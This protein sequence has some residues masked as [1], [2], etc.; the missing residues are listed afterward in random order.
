[1]RLLN[2][3]TYE[4]ETFYTDVPEYAILSHT[5]AEDQELSFQDWLIVIEKADICPH[6]S[7][8]RRQDSLSRSG[9]QKIIKFCQ[10]ALRDGYG[11]AW[12]DTCCT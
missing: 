4:F 6:V 10:L 9:H 2:T 11:F 8:H 12:V 5:W 1:M 7:K 3:S